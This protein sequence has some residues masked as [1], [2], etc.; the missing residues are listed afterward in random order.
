MVADRPVRE[1]GHQGRT[2][3]EGR[4]GSKFTLRIRN[5]TA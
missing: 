1:W 3:I 5:N 4:K 2:Y